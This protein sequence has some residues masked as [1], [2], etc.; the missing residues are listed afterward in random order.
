MDQERETSGKSAILIIDDEPSI[1]DL[2]RVMLE[3]DGYAIEAAANGR[4]AL[5][6]LLHI[7]RPCLILLDLMMPL[8]NGWQFYDA[9]KADPRFHS[10]PVVVVTA[11]SKREIQMPALEILAKPIDYPELQKLCVKYCGPGC[12]E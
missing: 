10:I 5:D 11:Y 3:M 1:R 8:M 12:P 6:L 9:L 2:L 4:Q 7:P